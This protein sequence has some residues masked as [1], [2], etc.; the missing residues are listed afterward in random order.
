VI[1][2]KIQKIQNMRG[3][4]EDSQVFLGDADIKKLLIAYEKA[5]KKAA[6]SAR[7]AI[8]FYKEKD[9]K[10]D[11]LWDEAVA[12]TIEAVLASIQSESDEM[13]GVKDGLNIYLPTME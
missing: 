5:S 9:S 10:I 1:K 12:S 3:Y 11:A 8:I 7:H 2:E 6:R 13:D 4:F